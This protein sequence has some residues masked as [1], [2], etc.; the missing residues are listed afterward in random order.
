MFVDIASIVIKAGNG[1]NGA[2]AFHREK[3][4]AA[5]GPDG[6]DGGRG[7][8]VIIVVDT[9]L[10]TLMD[11]RYKKKYNAPNGED[12]RGANMSGK[13]GEDLIIRVPRGTIVKDA[14]TDRIIAD[15]SDVDSRYVAARGG[16]G[17]WGNQHFASPTRQ[18]PNFAKSGL[19]GLSLIH[20]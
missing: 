8:D 17:G 7:G 10:S 16:N 1:G 20:I 19:I 4:V 18:A 13:A 15:L 9:N 5:G 6:G 14:E 3:Y 2:V 12:G 11:F